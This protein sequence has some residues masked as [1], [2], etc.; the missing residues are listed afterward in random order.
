M[1]KLEKKGRLNDGKPFRN[2]DPELSCQNF[3]NAEYIFIFIWW[4]NIYVTLR[5][6]NRD[7]VIHLSLDC[8]L[9]ILFV[10]GRP[11]HHLVE[12]NNGE[13]GS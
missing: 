8:I 5:R 6:R 7:R 13:E 1:K 12:E 9:S 3:C 10:F 4:R 11:F 2:E